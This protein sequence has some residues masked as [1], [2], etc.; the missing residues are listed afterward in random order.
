MRK[1][2]G[3]RERGWLPDV[4]LVEIDDDLSMPERVRYIISNTKRCII[5]GT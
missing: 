2:S 5:N 1:S 3:R 4:L